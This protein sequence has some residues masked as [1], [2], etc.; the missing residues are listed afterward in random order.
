MYDARVELRALTLLEASEGVR[1]RHR[2]AV[3]ASRRHCVEGVARRNDAGLDRY[4]V[5]AEAVGVPSAVP[6]LLR[7][8]DDA[9]ELAHEAADFLEHLLAPEGVRLDDRPVSLVELSG[10]LD[11]LLRDGDLANVV[12]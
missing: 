2:L 1:Q 4:R 10:L 7:C 6:A 9:A 5:A 3:G 11:D 8:P 12:K